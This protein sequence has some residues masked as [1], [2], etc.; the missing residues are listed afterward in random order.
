M[1]EGGGVFWICWIQ[2][3]KARVELYSIVVHYLQRYPISF[4]RLTRLTFDLF[5]LRKGERHTVVG[6]GTIKIKKMKTVSS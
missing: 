2:C 4:R 3:P 5:D 1:D 6:G